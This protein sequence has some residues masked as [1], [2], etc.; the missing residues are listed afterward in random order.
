MK[1]SADAPEYRALTTVFADKFAKRL[2][3]H[4]SDDIFI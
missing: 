4:L 1:C 2:T 3:T